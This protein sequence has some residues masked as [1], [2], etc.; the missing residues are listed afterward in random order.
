VTTPEQD[1]AREALRAAARSL[2]A[3]ASSRERVRE[4]LDDPLGFDP[5]L[6]EQM[7]DLGWLG[8][9]VPENDGGAGAG[10]GEVAVVLEELGRT[11]TPSPF[12][13]SAV[14][15]TSALVLAGNADQRSR[16]LA[17]LAAGDRIATVALTG[18]TG[19]YAADDVAVRASSEG[20]GWRLEGSA[21]FVPDAGVADVLV[22]RA[23]TED[24]EGLFLVD[25][26]A[27]GVTVEP[28][29][30]VDHT[31]R[32]ATVRFSAVGV[33]ETERIGPDDAAPIAAMLF[34]RAVIALALDA[35]GGAARILELTVEYVNQREQFG[36]PVGSFQAVK[37]KCA[38]MLVWSQG[39]TAAA[40]HAADVLDLDPDG[41]GEAAAV[42]GSYAL[43]AFA[44]V[45]GDAMQAHGGIGFTW[46]HDCHLFLKRAKLDQQLFGDP[47]FHRDRLARLRLAGSRP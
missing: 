36:R 19:R 39:A 42:A 6:W 31:R 12:T 4:L 17:P 30:T 5:K 2:L 11:L 26:D 45:A 9:L 34:D 29:P 8:L 33:D 32:L 7:A 14:L 38:D 3:R 20:G 1:E 47:A 28:T 41:S 40:E 18:P 44:H 22:V 27:R 23:R 10:F 25:Q 15:A 16:W 37:H 21:A 43:D 46:E 35:A 13:A 24:G